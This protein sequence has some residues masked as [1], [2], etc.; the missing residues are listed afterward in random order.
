M[1][2]LQVLAL[3]ANGR[4]EE[5]LDCCGITPQEMCSP[6]FIPRIARQLCC[7]HALDVDVPKAPHTPWGVIADWLAQAKQLQFRDPGKKVRSRIA[8]CMTAVSLPIGWH[9][10]GCIAW[11]YIAKAWWAD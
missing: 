4:I 6:R 5:W 10:T 7:F 1:L 8:R 2:G 3:F 11:D 9:Y